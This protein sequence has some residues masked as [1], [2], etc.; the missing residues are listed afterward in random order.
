MLAVTVGI[1]SIMTFALW[2]LINLAVE[3]LLL[4][5]NITNSYTQFIT[6]IVGGLGLIG[7]IYLFVRKKFKL[8]NILKD[9]FQL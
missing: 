4:K 2:N 8:L 3:D 6:I 1:I 7:I 9:V 5:M